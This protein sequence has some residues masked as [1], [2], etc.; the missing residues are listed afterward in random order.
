MDM[1]ESPLLALENATV[2]YPSSPSPALDGVDVA[3]H[4]GERVCLTG[5]NG[6]GKTTLLLA[7]IGLRPLRSGRLLHHGR[8]VADTRALFTLRKEAGIVFQHAEDQLFSPTVLE[9]VAF[10]PLNIGLTPSAAR[11]RA[12]EI[13]ESLDVTALAERMTHTL[14][15]GQKRMVALATALA[16][17]PRL[18]ILD[19]PTNDLD[20]KGRAI[21]EDYLPR[22]GLT[23]LV[24]SHDERFLD[25]LTTRRIHLMEGRITGGSKGL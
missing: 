5:D 25:T 14:S 23:L 8:A 2:H 7:L 10:G 9:D 12:L 24:V 22:S 6:S 19:E 20:A 21:L 15:G 17:R 18:L 16:M 11:Q 13:L 1:K 4:S 3:L